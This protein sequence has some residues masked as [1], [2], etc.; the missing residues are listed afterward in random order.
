MVQGVVEIPIICEFPNI[1]PEEISG[2]PPIREID[3]A[4]ELLPRT[5]PI[6]IAPYRMARVELGELKIQL[7]ELLD[8]GFVRPSISPGELQ[9]CL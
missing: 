9:F 1:F 2:L 6:S 5:A 8:Q 7:Q 4:I 3:F